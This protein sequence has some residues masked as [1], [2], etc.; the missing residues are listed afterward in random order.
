MSGT[1]KAAEA[2]A[3]QLSPLFAA[4]GDVNR[5]RLVHRLGDGPPRSIAQLAEGLGLTHQGVTKHLKVLENA[6]LVDAHRVGRE[7]RYR[8][9][10][11]RVREAQA[12]LDEVGREWDA[13]LLRL[14]DFVEGNSH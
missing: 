6:G 3:A 8:C 14:K 4:L 13:A 10:P 11:E 12:Y 7:R 2:R 9:R 5:L 1:D